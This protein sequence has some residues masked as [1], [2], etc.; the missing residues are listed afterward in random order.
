M[1]K[2]RIIILILLGFVCLSNVQAKNINIDEKNKKSV[3]IELD[4]IRSLVNNFI[5]IN[6]ENI[7][8][9][10]MDVLDNLLSEPE[11]EPQIEEWMMD[12]D[13]FLTETEPQIEGWMMDDDY[14]STEPTPEI[15]YWMMDDNYFNK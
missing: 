9:T 14:L 11:A 1:K 12:G 2:I 5:E 13:Y 6:H 3:K 15:E 8:F 4:S 10:F 7:E